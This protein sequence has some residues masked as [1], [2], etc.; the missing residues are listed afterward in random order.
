MET[1][2]VLLKPDACRARAHRRD[3]R[4]LRAAGVARPWTPAA[5]GSSGRPPRSHYAEHSERPFFGELVDF[6][7]GGPISRSRS[8]RRRRSRWSRG[9]DGR[10]ASQEVGTGHE[11]GDLAIAFAETSCTDPTRPSAAE[12]ELA[13]FFGDTLLPSSDP[14][15]P[16]VLAS[17]SLQRRALL[18][19]LQL[20]FRVAKTD[21]DEPALDVAPAELVR[22]HAREKAGAVAPQEGDGPVLGVDT[23]VVLADG[24]VL[25]K[26]ASARRGPRH[27][28]PPSKAASTAS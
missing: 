2:L 10:D 22:I 28:G 21:Y 13:L 1:T 23:A 4:P 12:R 3:P 11:R 17:R 8:G 27:A 19:Q 9:D 15:P 16:I 20:P 25:G 26:P 18:T 24:T 7:T 5:G 14:R 6:I